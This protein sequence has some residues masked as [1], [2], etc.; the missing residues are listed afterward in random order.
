MMFHCKNNSNAVKITKTVKIAA[1]NRRFGM[2]ESLNII[3][4]D[5]E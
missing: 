1:L 3:Q 4:I 5:G 2:K